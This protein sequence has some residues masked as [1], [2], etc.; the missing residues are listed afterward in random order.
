MLEPLD[1]A[2]CGSQQRVFFCTHHQF[3]SRDR[4]FRV[5]SGLAG[6]AISDAGLVGEV[7][8]SGCSVPDRLGA[9]SQPEHGHPR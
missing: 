2:G 1:E 4:R 7:M 8:R 9:R 6:D 5:Q 3:L